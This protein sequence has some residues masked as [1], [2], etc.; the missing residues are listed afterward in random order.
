MSCLH[1]VHPLDI[2]MKKFYCEKINFDKITAT[3]KF[4]PSRRSS[5]MIAAPDEDK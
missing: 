3:S 4:Y 2:C 5:K 1:D